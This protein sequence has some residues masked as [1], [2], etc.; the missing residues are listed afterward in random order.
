MKNITTG[1]NKKPL[2]GGA[3]ILFMIIVNTLW[4]QTPLGW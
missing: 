2:G 1:G 3:F 4:L